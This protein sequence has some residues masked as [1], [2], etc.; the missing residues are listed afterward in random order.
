[1]GVQEREESERSREIIF[2]KKMTKK[3][4]KFEERHKSSN[5]RYAPNSK[6][7]KPK[8]THT[9]HT[10]IKLL[11]YREILKVAGEKRFVTYRK[12][13]IE[14]YA[15]FFSETSEARRE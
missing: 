7:D 9:K 11:K 13:S 4:P 5:P 6:C 3:I 15:N 10:I 14:L 2:L 8:E 12:F 1:M